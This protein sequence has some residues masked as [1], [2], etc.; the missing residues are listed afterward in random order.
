[1][2]SKNMKRGVVNFGLNINLIL[3]QQPI[4]FYRTVLKY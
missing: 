1:M 4:V 2:N 3:L